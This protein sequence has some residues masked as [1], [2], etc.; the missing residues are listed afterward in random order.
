MSWLT[1]DF[2]AAAVAHLTLRGAQGGNEGEGEGE[3]AKKAEAAGEL[4][5]W[6]LVPRLGAEGGGGHIAYGDLGAFLGTG[7]DGRPIRTVEPPEW[8][9]A[10][11]ASGNAEMAMRAAVLEWWES[12]WTPF[13]LDATRTLDILE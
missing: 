9:A 4:R 11:R 5:I 1:A 13:A 10:L 3:N 6:H 2:L 8:F 7:Y 12:G